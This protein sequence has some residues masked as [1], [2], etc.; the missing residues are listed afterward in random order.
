MAVADVSRLAPA[1]SEKMLHVIVLLPAVDQ[2]MG[3]AAGTLVPAKVKLIDPGAIGRGV[4]PEPL[5]E[6]KKGPD[7]PLTEAAVK[8]VDGSPTIAGPAS[9]KDAPLTLTRRLPRASGVVAL[10]FA[11]SRRL[12]T[13]LAPAW[14]ATGLAGREEIV[15][16]P[17]SLVVKL[18]RA[19]G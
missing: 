8:L 14:R 12:A 10:L 11:K 16:L 4:K 19:E 2:T 7:K 17:T 15:A 9:E 3:V 5:R 6:E 13:R 18:A 1:A